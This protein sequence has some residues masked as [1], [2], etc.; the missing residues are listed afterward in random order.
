LKKIY[1]T[2]KHRRRNKRR[3]KRQLRRNIISKLKKKVKSIKKQGKS[4][5]VLKEESLSEGYNKITAPKHFSFI[6][7]PEETI[8][9]INKLEK[10]YLNKKNVFINLKDITFLD[11]SAVTILVSVMFSF[12]TRNIKFNGSFP[13]NPSLAKLLINSDF[14]KYLNKPIGEKIEYAIGKENQ[15]FTRANKEVNSEL[16]LVVM[17]EASMTIWGIKRTCKGLQR[18]L[19]ELMQNTNNHADINKKGEK[20]W[21]LSVNH[22]KPNKKVS[23]IFIDYG[24]GI[25]ESLKN[26]PQTNKWFGW[27]EKIKNRLKYGGNDEIF[28]MLLEGQM[29]LT[30]TGQ[31]F[32]G[33]GLPGINEVLGRNQISNLKIISNDVFSN[34]QEKQFY[35]LNSEFSGTFV[36]WELNEQNINTKWIT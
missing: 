21:W 5:F 11:Y 25:F 3:E 19:L 14:F 22:D 17:A 24:V 12:K 29:H 26:K 10:L 35:K 18:T 15:I 20:H 8:K 6:E 16:G 27:F 7:K 34:V 13:S 23:F 30:V 4:K 28:R 31:H 1:T 33:K 32:R 2:L 9:F 36:Y